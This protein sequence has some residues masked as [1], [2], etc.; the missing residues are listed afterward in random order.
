MTGDTH[1]SGDR[2]PDPVPDVNR[3]EP[4]AKVVLLAN[5]GGN[6]E[7]DG[8]IRRSVGHEVA[9][10]GSLTTRDHSEAARGSGSA[11]AVSFSCPAGTPRP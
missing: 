5:R 2:L 4:I 9:A 11:F 10:S 1:R 3:D 6:D 7:N 8:A